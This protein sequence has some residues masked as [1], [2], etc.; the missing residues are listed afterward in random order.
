[1]C[2]QSVIIQKLNMHPSVLL[3]VFILPHPAAGNSLGVSWDLKYI[4]V[5]VFSWGLSFGIIQAPLRTCL[6]HHN[7]YMHASILLMH[8]FILPPPCSW[9]LSQLHQLLLGV[10]W[11]LKYIFVW[12]FCEGLSQ[13][14]FENITIHIL[15]FVAAGSVVWHGRLGGWD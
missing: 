8:V 9:Q 2:G 4:F 3:H 14:F 1:M 13:G 5:W 7:L 11:D 15:V 12:V 6:V 10:S